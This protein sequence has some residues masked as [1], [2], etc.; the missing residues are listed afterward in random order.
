MNGT[1]IVP[2]RFTSVPA[3]KIQKL[4]GNPPKR[5]AVAVC[6]RARLIP[7]L[8]PSLVQRMHHVDWVPGASASLL[9]PVIIVMAKY[10]FI[11]KAFGAQEL[12]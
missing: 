9:Q 10:G 6:T 7:K 5:D 2:K 12:F 4:R 3:H 1:A 11:S 8:S